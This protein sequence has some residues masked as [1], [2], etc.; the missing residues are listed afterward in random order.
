M[1]AAP[2]VP[3]IMV[4]MEPMMLSSAPSMVEGQAMFRHCLYI[5]LSRSVPIGLPLRS[6]MP[7]SP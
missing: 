5:G 6:L 4:S 7:Q 1:A 3:T 2:R